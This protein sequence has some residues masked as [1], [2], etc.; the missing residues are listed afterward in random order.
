MLSIIYQKPYLN[1][2][3]KYRSA[4]LIMA[5]TSTRFQALGQTIRFFGGIRLAFQHEIDQA[6]P[7]I[8][9]EIGRKRL[10]IIKQTST[11]R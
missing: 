8:K 11:R 5:P 7:A 10:H 1:I 9:A 2:F 4:I 6:L 3:P